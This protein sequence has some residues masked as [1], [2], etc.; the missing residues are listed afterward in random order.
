MQSTDLL[1]ETEKSCEFT[2]EGVNLP[3]EALS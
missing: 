3:T 1:T 2:N